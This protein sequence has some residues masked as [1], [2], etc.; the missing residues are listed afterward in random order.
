MK[1]LFL[2]F[3]SLSSSFFLTGC[4]QQSLLHESRPVIPLF[5]YSHTLEAGNEFVLGR[6]IRDFFAQ[7]GI[8]VT[9]SS[10]RVSKLAPG[11]M[12]LVVLSSR[13]S[14]KLVARTG[15]CSTSLLTLECDFEYVAPS[16]ERLQKP[17]IGEALIHM[18]DDQAFLPLMRDQAVKS[19][20]IDIARGAY[21][22][23]ISAH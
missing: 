10:A 4:G 5:I 14:E 8:A 22:V 21:A 19:L 3:L 16:G 17:L 12:R 20:S 1:R 18:P 11:T 6:C 13:T 15:D 2:F 7:R 23:Y 9:C